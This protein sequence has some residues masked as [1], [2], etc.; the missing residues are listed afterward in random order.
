MKTSTVYL[1]TNL[2][3]GHTY[4]GITRFSPEYRWAQHVANA[5]TRAR[6]RLH[7]AIVKYGVDAFRVEAIASCLTRDGAGDV[8]RA[9]IQQ[10]HPTY[11]QT[12][13]G[14]VT[15]GRRGGPELYARIAAKARGR[16]H[17]PE[18]RAKNSAQAKARWASDPK[19]RAKAI[20]ALTRG[21]ENVDETKRIA[22][23]VKA[24]RNRKW[25]DESRAK[26]S[27]SCM[28]RRYHPD[29]L[30]RMGEKHKKAVECIELAAVF[31]SVSEAAEATGVSI[32]SVSRICLGQ[33]RRAHGLTF[34]FVNY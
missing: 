14:E 33:R 5:R 13:G 6:S 25:S 18:H 20:E 34:T 17:T 11:N 29:V 16:K 21:R 2:T 23:V 27:A 26:L 28:G 9:V 22:A 8:E 7:R 4:V 1:V 10:L 19:Y 24:Q 12:N 15:T 3:N 31:D 32:T 30:A